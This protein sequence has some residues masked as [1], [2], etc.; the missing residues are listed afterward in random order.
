[1]PEVGVY[2]G[3][4]PS[5]VAKFESWLGRP[6]D[7]VLAYLGNASWS[8]FT[9]GAPWQISNLGSINHELYWSVPLI[10]NGA[11]LSAAAS[12]A[13]DGYWRQVADQLADFR[14]GDSAI[15]IRT[16]W[17]HNG[18]WMPWNAV[19]QE[20]TFVKAFQRFVD[21]FRSVSG[22]DRFEFEWNVNLGSS[23][24]DPTKTYPG[25]AYVDVI[26]GDF[27]WDPNWD[28]KNATDAWN[29]ELNQQFG[30]NWLESF[31][32]AHNKPTAYSEWG[33]PAGYDATA[34]I[35]KADAWFDSHNVVYQTYWDSDA[36]FPGKLSD[37]TDVA[38]GTAY[39]AAF[40]PT[41]GRRRTSPSPRRS[42]PGRTAWS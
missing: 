11:T 7:G 12:G 39:K 16:A 33:V 6:V 27:Y 20:A 38:S 24:A 36:A 40:G 15:Y 21:V 10:V 3:N 1:M 29:N 23:N 19:G 42:A 37:G 4:T 31:A 28:P 34:F 5:D 13:Y 26:G 8:D 18:D 32:A 25:D 17:E 35:Q 41:G 9:N 22:G 2:V 30:L 14:P